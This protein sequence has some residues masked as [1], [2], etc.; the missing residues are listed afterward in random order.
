MV[1]CEFH[2]FVSRYAK[3]TLRTF[4]QYYVTYALNAPTTCRLYFDK[5]A[6]ISNNHNSNITYLKIFAY[7]YIYIPS[8]IGKVKEIRGNH[9]C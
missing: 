1:F 6:Q 9:I 4:I 8:I 2:I 7:I 3:F 5:E